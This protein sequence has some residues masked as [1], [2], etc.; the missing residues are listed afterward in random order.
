MIDVVDRSVPAVLVLFLYMWMF[1]LIDA[2]NI[3]PGLLGQQLVCCYRDLL[4][5][6]AMCDSVRSF[7]APALQIVYL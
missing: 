6:T 1:W 7:Y 2:D 4:P 3:W 5:L